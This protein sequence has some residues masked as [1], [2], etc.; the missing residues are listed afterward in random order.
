[1]DWMVAPSF[2]ALAAA[3]P[4]STGMLTFSK[5]RMIHLLTIWFLVSRIQHKAQ[6]ALLAIGLKR[7]VSFEK[8]DISFLSQ[9]QNL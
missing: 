4:D 3:F 8:T 9:L 2:P 1:M 6:L 5:N 7:S